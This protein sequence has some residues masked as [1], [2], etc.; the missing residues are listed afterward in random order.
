ME[1]TATGI[2][3]ATWQDRQLAVIL[4]RTSEVLRELHAANA[5][6]GRNEELSRELGKTAVLLEVRQAELGKAA[7]LLEVREAELRKLHDDVQFW[8]TRAASLERQLEQQAAVQN[9]LRTGH[10][11]LQ[12]EVTRLSAVE[13]N[14]AAETQAL[15][16][17]SNAVAFEAANLRRLST[18]LQ[19]SLSWKITAP[20]RFLTKP[21]FRILSPKTASKAAPPA[22]PVET[23]QEVA[24]AAALDAPADPAPT[25]VEQLARLV[26]SILPELRRAKSIAIIPC[27]IPFSSTLNQRPISCAR[28]LA[29]RG[30]T[31]LYV[32]WQWFPNE[33][34]PQA[35]EQVYPRVFHVPLYAFLNHVESIAQASYAKSTYFCTLPSPSLVDV[36]RPLRSAGYHIHYDIM[37]DWEGFHRGGEAPWFSADVEQEI[38]TLAD[39]VSAVSEKLVRKFDHVRSDIALVRNG[40]L[41]AAMG[42][43]QF[44]AARTPL[45]S[46]KTVGYFGHFSDA[47]FDWDAVIY[48]AQTLPDVKFELI[49]WAVSEPTLLRLK[50]VP[51]IHLVG[52]VPQKELHRYARKW[53][54][55]IIPFQA[56]EVSA[57]VDPLKIYEYLHLGLPS[58]VT[59]IG[60]IAGFPLV[61]FAEGRDSF[62]AA[63]QQVTGRPDEER[64]LEVAEFLKECVW[65]ERFAKLNAMIAEPAGLASLYAR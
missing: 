7:A 28:Y 11:R 24:V 12:N 34:V 54:V 36:V 47:W 32:A 63:L 38:A 60:G 58:V 37:D 19:T 53:W 45:E 62:V 15:N 14:Y 3:Y 57:A 33:P 13:S 18:E 61:Q 6:A 4:S 43:D 22:S 16:S 25:A 41:P 17:R 51:N 65:E 29:D 49:G 5:V 1:E 39:T 26:E 9:E 27:A 20:L 55:G 42:C 35:G 8:Q 40:Y 46:P 44:I 56:T 30:T 23:S 10:Q 59:G 21:L 31:V 50:G 48:A 52:I 2:S 64:L